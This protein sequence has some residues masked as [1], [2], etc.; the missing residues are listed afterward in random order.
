MKSPAVMGYQACSLDKN[1]IPF[2]EFHFGGD[3]WTRTSDPL[4]VKQVL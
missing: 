2:R 1:K 3:N 4:H